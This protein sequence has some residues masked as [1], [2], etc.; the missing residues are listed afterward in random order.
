MANDDV[1]DIFKDFEHK[2]DGKEESHHVHKKETH[3]THK[4]HE[5]KLSEGELLK[6]KYEKAEQ[7]LKHKYKTEKEALEEK[8]KKEIHGYGEIPH[9]ST[10]NIERVAYVAVILV[11]IV[12]VGIDLTFYH[13]DSASEEEDQAITAAAV[14]QEDEANETEE[15]AEQE[16]VEEEVVVEEKKLSGKII[17]VIDKVYTE[18]P[19]EDKDL[20]YITKVAFTIDNGKKTSFKPILFVYAYD[21][22]LDE[23][24]ETRGRG[25]YV[26]TAIKSGE[27]Q[28]GTI[29]VSPKTFRNLDIKKSIRLTLNDTNTGFFTAVNKKVTIS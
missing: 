22:E 12:Y 2:V 13:G 18:V 14:K 10:Q 17:L 21:S 20:G 6:R 26:G 23:S 9:K 27:K 28:T 4:S 25:K 11:L 19:D 7:V 5:E 15:V 29:E 1:D 3:E 16:P 24:W 8:K